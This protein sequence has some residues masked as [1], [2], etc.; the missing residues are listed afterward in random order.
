MTDLNA[1]IDS[2][3]ENVRDAVIVASEDGRIQRLGKAFELL[4]A[5]QGEP[6][7]LIAERL[8]AEAMSAAAAGHWH[9]PAR[10]GD[11]I[12]RNFE[13]DVSAVNGTAAFPSI[14]IGMVRPG[15]ALDP[16]EANASGTFGYDTLTGLPNRDLF[17]DR[18]GQSVLQANRIGGSLALM[19][20]G[21]DRFTLVNDALGH[22]AGDR[23][24]VEV[25]RR[26]KICVR[27]TD[28]AVRLE[29]DKFALVL[30]IADV[31]DSVIVA[32]K[33]L[34]SVK[35]PFL[36]DG[37]E[38]VA[39]F[40]IGISVLP[41]DADSGAQLINHAE[42]ALHYAKTSG[43]NQYQFF[44]KDMN[45]K[46]RSRLELETRMRRALANDEFVVFYQPKVSADAD[47]IVGAEALIR[48]MD[49]ERGMISPAD[50]IPI[51]EESG[52]IEAIGTWVLWKS[53]QQNKAWQDLGLNP[54]K[55]SVNVSARQFHSRTLMDSVVDVLDRTGLDPKWLELEITESMLMNDVDTAVRKMKALRDLGIGLS[56]DDFGT[57]YS[58]L[59]YLGRFPITTLKIDRA[60]I[61]D[62]DT[63]PK[64]AEIARAIIGLSRGL[65]LEVV[66]EGAEI[67]AHV[68]FLRDNG[69]DTVQ[70]FYYSRPVAA[71]DFEKMMR[72][73]VMAH[74]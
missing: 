9:G 28:T 3:L 36:L 56:I 38:V 30:A 7:T 61:A 74:S 55:V 2:L 57:G 21:L 45:R 72:M 18:V 60:F 44:S 4:V 1:L 49:P 71:G 54:I 35:E 46:A 66:A 50:F 53:C 47:K 22:G 5:H 29:G 19:M 11:G 59:S 48:W 69:C 10:C 27:E 14:Y 24:L 31:D 8:M 70:G 42:H 20:M 40:S 65:N 52:Q 16:T 17:I 67:A 15:S 23:L 12:E 33:V 39:T 58:S 62:V 37:Q 73:R 13:V 26:L 51:A 25:A 34:A 63:N 6:A 68:S 64:T 43:R 32:E 41:V